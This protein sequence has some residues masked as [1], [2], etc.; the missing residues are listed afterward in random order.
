[1]QAFIAA[2]DQELMTVVL[3]AAVAAQPNW[4]AEVE[5]KDLE[6]MA[7]IGIERARKYGL[8]AAE[9]LAAFV[10]IMFAVAPRF[11]EQPQIRQVL[12]DPAF[13]PS[14]RFYQIFDRVQDEHWKAA[15]KLY[16]DSFWFPDAA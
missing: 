16:E 8:S 4:T 13:P 2:D 9:D 7:R 3:P 14:M 1:M 6:R 5:E 12:E 15:E 11:D 10:A